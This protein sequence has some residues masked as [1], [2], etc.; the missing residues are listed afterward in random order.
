MHQLG[1]LLTGSLCFMIFVLNSLLLG[2]IIYFFIPFKFFGP[3]EKVKNWATRT[4]V[5]IAE[6]W[7]GINTW[8]ISAIHDIEWKISGLESLSY[9]KSYLVIANHRSWVDI[10][11]LQKTLNKKIPFLRFF[12]KRPLI[13]IPIL[14]GAWWALDFPFLKRHSPKYLSKHPEKRG[15]DFQTIRRTCESFKG[16]PISILNFLEGTRFT[17]KKHD[18]QKPPYSHLLKPK[19]GGLAF[20][21]DAMGEQFDSLIDVTIYYPSV[22]PDLWS[23]LS[24]SVKEIVVQIQTWPIPSELSKGNY[25]EDEK[26]RKKLHAWIRLIWESKDRRLGALFN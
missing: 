23:L 12:L 3:T 19:L 18:A 24:G 11:V 10:P 6:I 26:S 2:G 7:I 4:M 15:E 21:L 22:S 17:P 13:Y 5:S 8:F 20:V 25:F 1:Q 16:K 9:D 14:G